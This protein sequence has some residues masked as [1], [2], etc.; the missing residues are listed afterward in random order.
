M[1]KG[2]T[3]VSEGRWGI[4]RS[5]LLGRECSAENKDAS[6][7]RFT[8]WNLLK[9][10]RIE[11]EHQSADSTT[12]GDDRL[13]VVL[14]S[15]STKVDDYCRTSEL[16]HSAILAR[17]CTLPEKGSLTMRSSALD[18]WTDAD[19]KHFREQ[20]G[21]Q[22]IL[23]RTAQSD[24]DGFLLEVKW[25]Y[26]SYVG[27]EYSLDNDADASVKLLVRERKPRRKVAL[28]ELVSHDL[29]HGV[30]NTGQTCVWD[31]ESTLTYCLLNSDSGLCKSL[32]LLSQL[33]SSHKVIE[34]GVGMA[35]LAG[36][37]LAQVSHAQV[38][39]TDGH[40][41]AVENNKVNIRMNRRRLLGNVDCEELLWSTEIQKHENEFDLLL[42][43]DCTHF[44]KHHAGLMVALGHML[45]ADGVAILC[46]P[47][48]GKSLNRFMMLCESMPGLWAV[49]FVSDEHLERRHKESKGDPSYDPNLHC[50][51]I[52]LLR[53]L[54]Q[55]S[56]QDRLLAAE[57]VKEYT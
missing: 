33:S 48:R 17:Q 38:L 29:N 3:T 31:S 32:P 51:H 47:P 15:I 49:Q 45:K 14:E 44:E 19:I 12:D 43:S 46:Q 10:Q 22:G 24:E 55:L 26:C 35:G 1:T 27:T 21:C 30:D 16:V 52:V 57:I 8:G 23:A 6:I 50:P 9:K 18:S 39:L 13:L 28:Q 34:L 4:L 11:Q 36:L 2:T 37:A 25:S 56:S 40:P 53:K 7:H 41:K 42:C 20:L 5:A 54:R